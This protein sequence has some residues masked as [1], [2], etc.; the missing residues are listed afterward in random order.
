MVG[1]TTKHFRYLI[2]LISSEVMLYTEM[3]STNSFRFGNINKFI[4]N[5]NDNVVI[6]LAGNNPNELAYC[7]YTINIY[8]KYIITILFRK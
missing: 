1:V 8:Y 3:I 6:Q 5:N 2:R 4:D 7:S